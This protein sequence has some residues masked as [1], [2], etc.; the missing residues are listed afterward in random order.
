LVRPRGQT[1]EAGTGDGPLVGYAVSNGKAGFGRSGNGM[2]LA[3]SDGA[4]FKTA[5]EDAAFGVRWGSWQGG[6]VAVGGRTV[7]G[8]VHLIDSTMKTLPDQLAALTAGGVK[9]SYSYNGNGS[10]SNY[11]G[12]A[13]AIQKLEVGVDFGKQMITNYDLQAKV[14]GTWQASGGGSF[15]QFTGASGIQLTGSCSGCNLGNGSPTA[16]GTAHGAFVGDT[17]QKMITSFGLS[18]AGQA[19]SGAALLDGK[20]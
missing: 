11:L 18:S 17:A 3:A 4:V 13:G 16:S 12:Q 6:A 10:V 5:G 7:A 14:I 2:A 8:P 9:G 19:I 20:K 15:A 1:P